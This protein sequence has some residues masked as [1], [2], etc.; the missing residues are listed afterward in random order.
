MQIFLASKQNKEK[1]GGIC[2]KYYTEE[3]KT[4][5]DFRVVG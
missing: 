3:L 1:Y 2:I 4:G 5:S